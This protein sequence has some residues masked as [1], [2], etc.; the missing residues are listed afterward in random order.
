MADGK[1]GRSSVDV[2][3]RRRTC[4]ARSPARG[5]APVHQNRRGEL[6]RVAR[7]SGM[8]NQR[9]M[10]NLDLICD[11]FSGS[12]FG[13][14]I[15]I[16]KRHWIQRQPGRQTS[17]SSACVSNCS[18]C[19]QGPPPQA[20]LP[21]EDRAGSPHCCYHITR[22][23]GFFRPS[24]TV[25]RIGLMESCSCCGCHGGPPPPPPGWHPPHVMDGWGAR[26][27]R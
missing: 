1:F 18:A 19:I 20:S 3:Q 24:A 4:A 17:H 22:C 8:V 5:R 25:S 26:P 11:S 15:L 10:T 2:C 13:G 7:F 14:F 21:A 23:A 27:M 9:Q 12:N 6:S 16:K